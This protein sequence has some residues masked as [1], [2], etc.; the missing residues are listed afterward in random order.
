MSRCDV[1]V[2]YELLTADFVDVSAQLIIA[3][4]DRKR[5]EDLPHLRAHLTV[6]ILK[7]N[8]PFRSSLELSL[9]RLP[10]FGLTV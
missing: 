9:L 4:R 7:Y 10:L 1:L 6:D 2:R 8:P 5:N 3:S